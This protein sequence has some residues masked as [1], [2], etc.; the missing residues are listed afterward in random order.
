MADASVTI[1]IQ[2]EKIVLHAEKAS[3]GEIL[4]KIRQKYPVE[5]RGMEHREEEILTFSA[6]GTLEDVIKRLLRYIG[7][8][9]CAFEFTD[10][11]L[12]RVSVLPKSKTRASSHFP[13]ANQKKAQK[14]FGN[15]VQVKGVNKGTQAEE[16]ELQKDDLIVEYDGVKIRSAQQLVR[17]VKKKSDR[18]QVEMTVMRDRIPIQFVLKGGLIGVRI[19]TIKIPKEE[20]DSY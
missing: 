15:V 5:I 2:K 12:T 18:E 9:N 19:V 14:K 20:L 16:L 6:K 1:E 13:K 8:E 7:E 3:V 17:E 11:R 10:V 4:E